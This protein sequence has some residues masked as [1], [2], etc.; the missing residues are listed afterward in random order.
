MRVAALFAS[1]QVVATPGALQDFGPAVIVELL[2]RH[3]AGDW[4]D[5][6][7]HD[8]RANNQALRTGARLL[9][10]YETPAGRVWIITEGTDDTGTRRS[11]CVL[12]PQDY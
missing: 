10:A 2:Q 4:G 9:S 5:L 12:R 1:G 8:I 6:D 11:T 3:L 7:S